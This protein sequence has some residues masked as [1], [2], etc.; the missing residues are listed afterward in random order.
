MRCFYD[1][2]TLACRRCGHVARRLPTYRNCPESP[3][4]IR[5]PRVHVGAA[6]ERM[7]TAIGIT[8]ARVKEW[9]RLKDCGCKGRARWLDQWGYRQTHRLER[10]LNKAARWYG[11][12]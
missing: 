4:A 8:E 7:L 6:V 5:L 3:K 11:I 12:T 10:L 2:E 9:T 1:P